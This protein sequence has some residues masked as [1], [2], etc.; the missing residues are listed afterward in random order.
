MLS[1]SARYSFGFFIP[2]E[3]R[4]AAISSLFYFSQLQLTQGYK[5]MLF[6]SDWPHTFTWLCNINFFNLNSLLLVQTVSELPPTFQFELRTP[7]CNDN[8]QFQVTW[9]FRNHSSV[10]AWFLL[11]N[12]GHRL[13]QSRHFHIHRT[14]PNFLNCP[15][16]PIFNHPKFFT[17][18]QKNSQLYPP[19]E[20][21]S[22]HNN[23]HSTF[24]GQWV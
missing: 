18:F 7:N 17:Y 13:L 2:F 12:Y 21:D 5:S 8:F 14:T 4:R 15:V 10:N 3:R 6:A 22:R 24:S 20:T 9:L 19:Y 11:Q 1:C 23:C 16:H